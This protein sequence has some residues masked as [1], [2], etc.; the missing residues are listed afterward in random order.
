MPQPYKKIHS[1]LIDELDSSIK[2]LLKKENR[3]ANIPG[4]RLKGELDN[5]LNN[6]LSEIERQKS[7]LDGQYLLANLNSPI[8]F[9]WDPEKYHDKVNE[10][11]DNISKMLTNARNPIIEKGLNIK[12]F[13]RQLDKLQKILSK[14]DPRLKVEGSDNT[15]N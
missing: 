2:R 9:F 13:D 3:T 8:E 14:H 7:V 4:F 6:I 12:K 1:E 11:I 5:E 15:P 10:F